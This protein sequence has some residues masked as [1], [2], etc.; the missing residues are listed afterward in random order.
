MQQWHPCCAYMGGNTEMTVMF[1]SFRLQATRLTAADAQAR[2]C[3]LHASFLAGKKH[4][5]TQVVSCG[6]QQPGPL[7]GCRQTWPNQYVCIQC[8]QSS[9]T[10]QLSA[11]SQGLNGYCTRYHSS[12][13]GP[14]GIPYCP[15]CPRLVPG[16]SVGQRLSRCRQRGPYREAWNGC[17]QACRIQAAP[18]HRPEVA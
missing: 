4:E 18:G 5:Q 2:A 9:G 17:S 7:P 12:P 1:S 13:E 8:A 3:K 6:V 14:R 11:A 10:H 16:Y 15:H